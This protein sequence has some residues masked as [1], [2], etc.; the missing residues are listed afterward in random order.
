MALLDQRPILDH[1]RG[2]LLE[3]PAQPKHVLWP[4]WLGEERLRSVSKFQGVRIRMSFTPASLPPFSSFLPARPRRAV[5]WFATLRPLLSAGAGNPIAPPSTVPVAITAALDHWPC[6]LLSTWSGAAFDA[7]TFVSVLFAVVQAGKLG[8]I[9]NSSLTP[10]QT[11]PSENP[12]V[13]TV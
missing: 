10:L 7:F 6:W 8:I 12:A 13:S 5:G 2:H 11:N 4:H 1:S 9:F 3:W